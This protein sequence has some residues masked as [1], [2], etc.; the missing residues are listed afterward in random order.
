MSDSPGQV[1]AE[2]TSAFSSE[3]KNIKKVMFFR[4]G[5]VIFREDIYIQLDFQ[6][7]VPI[8]I[9]HIYFVFE[10]PLWYPGRSGQRDCKFTHYYN[11][12]EEFDCNNKLTV[13]S[14]LKK[15]STLN[16]NKK[17]KNFNKFNLNNFLSV[18]PLILVKYSSPIYCSGEFKSQLFDYMNLHLRKELETIFFAYP[19]VFDYSKEN[20][21]S[22]T[23]VE[24]ME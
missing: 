14:T 24:V 9:K 12:L 19:N 18:S 11:V 3:I 20:K 22:F 17:I 13:E 2:T 6:P 21:D 16:Q 4:D 23:E 10:T 1:P 8:K 15:S 5:V 7:E